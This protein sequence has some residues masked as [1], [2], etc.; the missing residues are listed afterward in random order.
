MEQ[1]ILRMEQT[2]PKIC[3]KSTSFDNNQAG[4]YV[5]NSVILRDI[6]PDWRMS[7]G[8]VGKDQLLKNLSDALNLSIVYT[9][10]WI[11]QAN[12]HLKKLETAKADEGLTKAMD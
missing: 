12:E 3:K 6:R 8:G 7:G 10:N 1:K 9:K 4:W 11:A 2:M 5:P